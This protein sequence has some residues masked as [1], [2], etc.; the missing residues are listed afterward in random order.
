[1]GNIRRDRKE[2]REGK[3][4]E[5]EKGGMNEWQVTVDEKR[6]ERKRTKKI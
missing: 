6:D 3:R 2:E 5:E 4:V 1:M